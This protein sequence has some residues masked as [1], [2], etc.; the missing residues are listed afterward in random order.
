MKKTGD[1][2]SRDTLP[3]RYRR[4][5]EIRFYEDFCQFDTRAI[6]DIPG[7]LQIFYQV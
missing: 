7:D 3:L 2:K 1:R 5:T 6:D 4:C